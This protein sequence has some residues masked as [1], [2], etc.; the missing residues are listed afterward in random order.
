M[1]NIIYHPADHTTAARLIADL[2]ASGTPVRDLTQGG[3]N[4]KGDILIAVIS[5]TSNADANALVEKVLIQALDNSQHIIPVLLGGAGIPKLIDH[6][7][8]A[9]F[10]DAYD[11]PAV[12]LLV[13]DASHPGA[14]AP[15]RVLTPKVRRSNSRAGWIV[16]VASIFMFLVGLY[17]VGV[18]KIQQPQEEYDA[19]DATQRAMIEQE[20]EPQLA[21]AEGFLPADPD[22]AYVYPAT[23]LAF[24]TRLRPFVVAT[25]TAYATQNNV[26]PATPTPAN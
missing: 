20:L 8:Y 22:Q 2:N 15:I 5:P 10:T 25:A 21:T 23:A 1:L 24:P 3:E 11:F 26:Y 13:E 12:Q 7:Q 6:L 14:K 9:N 16:A 4:A 17:A 19:I 18:L